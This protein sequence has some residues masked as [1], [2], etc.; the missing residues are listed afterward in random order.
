MSWFVVI[1][2][3]HPVNFSRYLC[4]HFVDFI[5]L[6]HLICTTNNFLFWNLLVLSCRLIINN[7]YVSHKYTQNTPNLITLFNRNGIDSLTAFNLQKYT[8]TKCTAVNTSEGTTHTLTHTH[9]IHRKS[10]QFYSSRPLTHFMNGITFTPF[11][12]L[13]RFNAISP[14]C[15]L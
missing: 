15:I 12:F 3:L 10:L 1:Q 4:M 2:A 11:L 13:T 5:Y 6:E 9:K 14:N 7:Y 8:Y